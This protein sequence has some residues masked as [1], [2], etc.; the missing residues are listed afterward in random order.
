MSSGGAPGLGLKGSGEV[1]GSGDSGTRYFLGAIWERRRR[2]ATGGGGLRGVGLVGGGGDDVGD[3]GGEG[4]D[5]SA[6][7]LASA[8]KS[9]E[10]MP[11]LGEKERA[12]SRTS[13]LC[14]SPLVFSRR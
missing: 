7:G 5:G 1:G 3:A 12:V 9:R 11:S 13:Y 2:G 4:A 10:T 6:A 8:R 14:T